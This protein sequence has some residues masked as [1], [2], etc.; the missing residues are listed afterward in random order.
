[1]EF[2]WE[3]SSS[4]RFTDIECATESTRISADSILNT[5]A[6]AWERSRLVMRWSG[7][8]R[9]DVTPSI[10]CRDKSR[11]STHGEPA[12]CRA[13]HEGFLKCEVNR[14]CGQLGMLRGRFID[15]GGVSF[16]NSRL[17]TSLRPPTACVR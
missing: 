14:S 9:V 3:G 5:L 4:R 11:I 6:R 16:P 10:F 7:R 13:W 17:R 1:M 12:M 15:G 2:A 8:C